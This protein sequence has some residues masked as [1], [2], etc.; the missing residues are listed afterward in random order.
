M[1]SVLHRF[2]CLWGV[3]NT[4]NLFHAMLLYW[5]GWLWRC[6][7]ASLLQPKHVCLKV[8]DNISVLG[9]TSYLKEQNI[10]AQDNTLRFAEGRLLPIG[11]SCCISHTPFLTLFN[12]LRTPSL[13]LSC[14]L[15]L[16]WQS[17]IPCVYTYFNTSYFNTFWKHFILSCN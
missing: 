17:V 4:E 6:S 8:S 10:I 11:G 9:Q 3:N 14:L 16:K 1:G 7:L 15:S 2:Q 12:S 13:F 5:E